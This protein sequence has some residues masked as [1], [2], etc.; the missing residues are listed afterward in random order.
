MKKLCIGSLLFIIVIFAAGIIN[1]V[2]PNKPSVSLAENRK[3]QE[4]PV[5]PQLLFLIN[6]M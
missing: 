2:N 1:I 6:H 5:F 3:L 4:K